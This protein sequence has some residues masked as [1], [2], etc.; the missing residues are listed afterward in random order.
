MLGGIGIARLSLIESNY[1]AVAVPSYQ[2]PVRLQAN[3]IPFGKSAYKNFSKAKKVQASNVKVNYV[4]SLPQKPNYVTLQIADKVEVL[5][6]L[7][8]KKNAAIKSFMTNKPDSELIIEL[9]VVFNNIN[10]KKLMA[11]E[12]IFLVETSYKTYAL[13]LYSR[14]KKQ[15]LIS[16]GEGVVFGYDKAHPCWQE[17]DHHQLKI[18]DLVEGSCSKDT[19]R[20]SKRAKKRINYFKL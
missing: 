19:Y 16:I 15:G 8:S 4:D 1:N 7:N 9:S 14:G 20:Y 3:L 17:D 6:A 11:A 2:N 5:K 12:S 13:E 10:L 18:V